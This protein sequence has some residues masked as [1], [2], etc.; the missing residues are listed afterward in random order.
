[1]TTLALIILALPLCSFTVLFLTARQLPRKG[2]YVGVGALTAAW[3]LALAMFARMWTGG[4]AIHINLSVG[5]FPL[6][7]ES[8]A[9]LGLLI[10]NL[11]I[12]MLVVVTTVSALVHWYSTGYMHGDA[13]YG[14]YFTNLSLFTF[15]MLGLVLTN[16]LLGLYIC[17][18]LVGLSSYLLIGHFFEKRSAM[19]AC[20]KAF[21]T[22]RVG[23]VGMFI[24][25]MII[26]RELGTFEYEAVFRAVAEGGLSENLRLVAGLGLF[27]GAVGKSAQFP[28][29]V[30]LPDAMEGPTPV[31]ALIHAATMVAAGVYLVGRM[32]P[33]FSADTLIV[34][35][36]VGGFTA[37]FAATIA[38]V[39][40]DIKRVLAYSTLSQL[41]YMMLAL[42][43]GGWTAGLFH[44]T[45]HA[46]FKAL[47]FLGSGSVI[48]AV[49]TNSISLMGGLRRKMPVTF[50]TFLV[51]TLAISGIPFFS[52]FYSKDMIVRDALFF[53][54]S[55]EG[56]YAL[57]VI[58]AVTAG[59]TAF[60]MFRLT[61]VTFTGQPRDP[62]RFAH[63]HESPL[64]MTVPLV[65]LAVLSV[66]SGY[67]HWFERKV[68]VPS[69]AQ[70]GAASVAEHH[71]G[72]FTPAQDAPGGGT[73]PAA[74]HSEE[75]A[76]GG[77]DERL[78]LLH[79]R[80]HRLTMFTVMPLVL[81]GIVVAAAIYLGG[82]VDPA[83]L[84]RA[85]GPLYRVLLNKYY[86]DEIYEALIIR[87]IVVLFRLMGA[88]D[89]A[90]IDGIV[91]ACGRACKAA[92]FF[93]R[94]VDIHV[95]D[96]AV[97]ASAWTAGALGEALSFLQ[98]G[99]TRFYAAMTICGFLALVGLYIVL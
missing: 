26:Y 79:H 68:P 36:Y 83:R 42:G 32:F 93:I 58:A 5:W 34:V 40:D 87:P 76:G 71:A 66:G 74:G 65:V 62:H 8:V 67:G 10:D 78:E 21:I 51:A 53:A 17:W 19:L 49:H 73:G 97:N 45:T 4:E 86:I 57:F 63:A 88:F 1:M 35:A 54:M 2:D 13:K 99:R 33:F 59:L 38:L 56:H 16:N 60:Y 39:Q 37:I 48:H 85:A 77:H 50:A 96:G 52:G 55:R 15:S 98:S 80:A 69:L 23:D 89:L 14:R 64:V 22:T 72:A 25:I 91:N 27:A 92:A 94:R 44:L 75:P 20:K 28:L 41:G 3:V 61:F 90:V 31:S 70:Y 11:T 82:V 43:V 18:E 81:L 30:W 12:V 84:A 46:F 29:H 95:V 47:L 6:G 9:P 24:G 7:I